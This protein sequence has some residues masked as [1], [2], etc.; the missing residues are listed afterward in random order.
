MEKDK[1]SRF[2]RN[3]LRKEEN[4]LRQSKHSRYVKDMVDDYEGRPEEVCCWRD[5]LVIGTYLA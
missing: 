1:S 4:T 5:L 3:A 2:E